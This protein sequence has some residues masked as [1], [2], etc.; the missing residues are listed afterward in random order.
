MKCNKG[1]YVQNNT[2]YKCTVNENLS[3]DLILCKC[4]LTDLWPINKGDNYGSQR[5]SQSDRKKT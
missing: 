1:K 2:K 5:T 3:E 4:A